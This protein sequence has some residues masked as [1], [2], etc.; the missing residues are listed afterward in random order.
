MASSP[1]VDP[2]LRQAYEE[3][4]YEIYAAPPFTLRIA[5]HHPGLQALQMAHGVASST[6][7]SASNPFSQPFPD[8]ENQ[9]RQARLADDLRTHGVTFID[10][11]GRHPSNQWPPEPS[12][13]ALGLSLELSRLLGRRY[14]Q[15]AI[16]WSAE[17]V[18]PQLILLR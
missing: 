9:L 15:N 14:D 3:T 4:H 17:D 7:L 11:L 10:A 12:F 2:A 6:F 1:K 13:L 5:M 16:V 18:V 8:A